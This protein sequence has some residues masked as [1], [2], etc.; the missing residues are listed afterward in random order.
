M[1]L[2]SP[3]CVGPGG[4]PGRQVFSRCGSYDKQNM[5]GVRE[6]GAIKFIDFNILSADIVFVIHLMI[7]ISHSCIRFFPKGTHMVSY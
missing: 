3:V 4:K 1:W 5:K 2:Y 7:F 6:N